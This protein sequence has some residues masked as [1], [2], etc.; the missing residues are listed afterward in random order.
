[1]NKTIKELYVK[2]RD[3]TASFMIHQDRAFLENVHKRVPKIEEFILWFMSENHLH[4]EDASYKIMCQN[5]LDILQDLLEAMQRK[6]MVMLNDALAYG[7]M[8]YLDLFLSI[9]KEDESD[10]V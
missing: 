7:F 5:L 1:M 2:L 4:I 3:D 10:T 9:E 8:D 6:D